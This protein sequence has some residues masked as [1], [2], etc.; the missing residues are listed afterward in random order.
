MTLVTFSKILQVFA[1]GLA[2]FIV[3]TVYE[4]PIPQMIGPLEG[5]EGRE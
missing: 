2:E 3:R 4:G 1:K 5:P